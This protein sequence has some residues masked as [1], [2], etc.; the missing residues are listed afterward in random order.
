MLLHAIETPA[1]VANL[2]IFD[3]GNG[4]QI[5]AKFNASVEPDVVQ[6]KLFVGEACSTYDTVFYTTDTAFTVSGL[7][8]NIKYYIG[9]AAV[10][11][12]NI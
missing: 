12:E 5:L 4:N 10:D 7:T 9:V 1:K 8:E 3:V 6:Y 2:H 11:S